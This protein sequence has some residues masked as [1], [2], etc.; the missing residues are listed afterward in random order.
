[1]TSSTE[2]A[3]GSTVR[4]PY[5]PNNT[6]PLADMDKVALKIQDMIPKPRGTRAADA[7]NNYEVPA[8]DNYRH[9]TIPSIKLDH[10][11]SS[12][13][14][15]S[16]YYA[17]NRAFSPQVND[18]QTPFTNSV[19]QDSVS[20]TVRVNYDQTVTPTML[21]HLGA[22]LVHT[23]L[24]NLT[25]DFDQSSLGW[26]G[27]FA[28]SRLFPYSSLG[29]DASRGG[30][31]PY[32]MG[33]FNPY[34]YI[35]DIK[36]TSNASLTWVKG[37]HTVKGGGEMIFE[38]FPTLTL[39]RA[40]GNYTYGAQQ[41]SDP[42][43]L[44]KGTNA[45]TGFGYASFLLGRSV[46]LNH[47]TGSSNRL[48][49]HSLGLY[50]QDTWKV[51]RKFTLDYGLRYDYVTLLTEQYGRMQ[52]AAFNL[53][54]PVAGNRLGTVIYEATCGCSFNHNYPF[55]FGPRLGAAY[56]INNKTVFRAG[57]G[58]AY[59]TAPNQAGLSANVGDFYTVNPIGYGE[60][61]TI[62]Q[63][64]NPYAKGNRFGNP[65][66]HWPDFNPNYP[67]QTAPGV[68][69]PQSPFIAV[70]RNSGRPPRILQ[71]SV[72]VQRELG[73]NLVVEAAY[74]GNR[75]VWWTSPLLFTQA[76]NALTPEGLKANYNIDTSVAGDRALLTFDPGRRLLPRARGVKRAGIA[77]W[78]R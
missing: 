77:P 44:G 58:V 65:E 70:D 45:F 72:G 59:G 3:D 38:G 62:L 32:I 50:I 64:G 23:T 12:A 27:N 47:G 14:R 75:G 39:S 8:Y 57:V 1:M 78:A 53:P 34:A 21:L 67:S 13:I 26:A 52:D 73:S 66:I 48:G 25:P 68:R 54:N 49:N 19:I 24:P 17:E 4:N 76:Y 22:G 6:I 35:K 41:T 9:T 2:L 18:Y 10:N 71:W 43:E 31:G 51:T 42:W 69:P 46:S 61:A 60:A 15:L 20:R 28:A 40:N 55:A 30:F 29:A 37:N 56:Q 5:T 33:I 11:L 7:I 16:G 36:P 74:V 63:D